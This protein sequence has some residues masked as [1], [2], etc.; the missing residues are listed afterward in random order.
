MQN[1][2]PAGKRLLMQELKIPTMLISARFRIAERQMRIYGG[3]QRQSPKIF[4]LFWRV[5]VVQPL[6]QYLNHDLQVGKSFT[7]SEGMTNRSHAKTWASSRR[8]F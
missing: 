1:S 8:K 3:R 6:Q 2:L 5:A 7:N 4:K